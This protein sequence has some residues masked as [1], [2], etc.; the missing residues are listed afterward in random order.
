MNDEE[1]MHWVGTA[2][3]VMEEAALIRQEISR[4][5]QEQRIRL[6]QQAMG[7]KDKAGA[8]GFTSLSDFDAL[9][10][11]LAPPLS[12]TSQ[13]FLYTELHRDPETLG[14]WDHYYL[15]R[16]FLEAADG[17][18]TVDSGGSGGADTTATLTLSKSELTTLL[19]KMRDTGRCLSEESVGNIPKIFGAIDVNDDDKISWKEFI[20]A[21]S[22]TTELRDDEAGELIPPI[23][24]KEVSFDE[25]DA[26]ALELFNESSRLHH[27]AMALIV[28][29]PDD[30]KD[31]SERRKLLEK[32]HLLSQTGE[33]YCVLFFV[34]PVWFVIS[35]VVFLWFCGRIVFLSFSC[36]VC[37]IFL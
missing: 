27:K 20:G 7:S 25:L 3:L 11:R 29:G 22:G 4:R 5:E 31:A 1:Q 15:K 2:K 21:I 19:D 23:C 24:W 13:S 6:A 28:N 35:V 10:K 34:G 33:F 37:F 36:S 12:G 8:E 18:D 14:A 17:D 9:I 30:T 26:R 32:A 16:L